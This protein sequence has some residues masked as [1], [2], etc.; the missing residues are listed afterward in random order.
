MLFVSFQSTNK[1]LL[2]WLKQ[3]DH[4][5]FNKEIKDKKAKK[6]GKQPLQQKNFENKKET[7]DG[8]QGKPFKSNQ[9]E[10]TDELDQYNRPMHKV[11]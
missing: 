2:K 1:L 3:W 9:P 11:V 4:V 6:S 10:V 7:K 8:K 5:V